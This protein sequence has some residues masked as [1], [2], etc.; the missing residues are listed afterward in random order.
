MAF[1]AKH[2]WATGSYRGW[3]GLSTNECRQV[4][5]IKGVANSQRNR[6]W[7]SRERMRRQV[8]HQRVKDFYPT[9]NGNWH[10]AMTQTML[11]MG[12]FL[13]DRDMVDRAAKS[14]RRGK[15]NG[16]VT[17]YINDS[18]CKPHVSTSW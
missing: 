15:G 10:A 11:A 2:Q 14:Y 1:V 4:L 12:V 3:L 18:N 5:D 16:A 13:D 17:H 8:F 7:G 9:A 6:C